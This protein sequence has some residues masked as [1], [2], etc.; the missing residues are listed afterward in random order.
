MEPDIVIVDTSQ[1][2]A[3]GEN[4]ITPCAVTRSFGDWLAPEIYIFSP[5]SRS[6]FANANAA[7]IVRVQS[8]AVIQ[9]GELVFRI[10]DIAVCE[11]AIVECGDVAGRVVSHARAIDP[12]VRG[13]TRCEA[14]RS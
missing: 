8:S 10:I 2:L 6:V 14:E 7:S 13:K 4:I 9:V 12:I 3:V 11:C 1:P 5:R